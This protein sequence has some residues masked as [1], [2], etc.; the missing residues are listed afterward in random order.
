MAE[1]GM[2]CRG[3]KSRGQGIERQVRKRMGR[4]EGQRNSQGATSL[5]HQRH[6]IAH[7]ILQRHAELCYLPRPDSHT[8]ANVILLVRLQESHCIALVSVRWMCR[9]NA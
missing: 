3:F 2:P 5:Q 6:S 1:Q 8:S 4:P 7:S 9:I